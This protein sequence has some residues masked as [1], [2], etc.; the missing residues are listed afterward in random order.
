VQQLLVPKDAV[1]DLGS[2][3]FASHFAPAEECGGDW[4]TVAALPDGRV[5]AV[6]GDVEGHGI[7]SAIITGAAKAT[8]DAAIHLTRGALTASALL[9]LMNHCLVEM[10]HQKITMTAVA[11]ILDPN[12]RALTLANAGHPFPFL[13]RKGI[14]HPLIA[15]GPPL[16]SSIDAAYVDTQVELQPG[17]V[18][19]CFTDGVSECENAAGE[20]FSDR[21]IRMIGQRNASAGARHVVDAIVEAVAAFRGDQAPADDVTL[22]A[23]RFG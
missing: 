2:L 17:D 20:Q 13:V 7:S 3:Q 11:A 14:T 12:A 6:I 21:R 5:L 22:L 18:M 10:T 1:V 19:V 23:A 16:G 8:C 15:E 4:W 9:G